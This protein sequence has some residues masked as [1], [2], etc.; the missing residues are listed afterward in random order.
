MTPP[1]RENVCG[2]RGANSP[3]LDHGRRRST[4]IAELHHSC[5]LRYFVLA[6]AMF[7]LQT[8]PVA[9]KCINGSWVAEPDEPSYLITPICEGDG[10]LTSKDETNINQY[11]DCLRKIDLSDNIDLVN[12]EIAR[13]KSM[14]L[15][16][17]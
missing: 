7:L 13:C 1:E 8:L 11:N 4:L 2:Q 3:T 9:A 5:I 15:N 10:P 17:Y 6:I 14:I 12:A 16:D